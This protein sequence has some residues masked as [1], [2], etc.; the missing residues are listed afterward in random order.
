MHLDARQKWTLVCG[1]LVA[2]AD[3]VLDGAEC[4]RLLAILDDAPGLGSDELAAWLAIVGDPA[5]LQE[6]LAGMAVPPAEVARDVLEHAWVT[7]VVD[8]ARTPDELVMIETIATRLGIAPEQLAYWREAWG[9]AEQ[10]F[11]LALADAIAAIV[12]DGGPIEAGDRPAIEP[13]LWRTP[14]PESLRAELRARAGAPLGMDE[15][16]ARVSALPRGRRAALLERLA[17][18]ARSV[19]DRV[20]ASDRLRAL[21][22]TVGVAPARVEGW[23]A[24]E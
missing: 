24:V 8:G 11:A 19:R 10:Q 22:E 13:A 23:L 4:E 7:A 3:G 16:A 1:G 17:P 5:R 21:A 20:G 2:H 9:V 12:G 15:A 18:V 6:L 14:C